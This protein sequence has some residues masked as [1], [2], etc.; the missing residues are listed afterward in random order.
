MDLFQFRTLCFYFI[1][2]LQTCIAI[3]QNIGQIYPG[4]NTSQMVYV[5]NNGLFR[6]SNN[7]V[8]AFGFKNSQDVTMFALVV[9]HINS[10][11]VVW[12]ANTGSMVTGSDNFV[13][14]NDGN[15]YLESTNGVIWS[16]NTIGERATAMELQDSGNLALLGDNGRILWQSFSHPTDTLL[17]N[18]EFFEGMQLKSSPNRNN[19]SQYLE[20]KSGNLV[21]YAG[22]KTPQIYWSIAND[23]RISSNNVSG[24]VYSAS[25][26]SNSWNFYDQRGTLLLQFTFSNHFELNAMWAA[27]LGSAGSISFYNLQMGNSVTPE[28]NRI[29]Q[30]SCSIPE[31]CNPYY[32]C[33]LSNQCQCPSVLSLQLN[34]KPQIISTCNSSK[35]SGDL[36]YVGEKL[37][38]FALGFV[39]PFLKSDI[40]ACKQACLQNCSCLVLFFEGSSGN[41]FLFDQIGSLQRASSAGYVSYVKVLSNGSNGDGGQSPAR[42]K[43]RKVSHILIIVIIVTATILVIVGLIFLAF[44]YDRKNKILLEPSQEDLEDD[45][46]LDSLSGMPVR[47]SYN[48]VYLSTYAF[49][50][51]EEEKL[52]EILDPKLETDESDERVITAI[53]VALWCIQE[54]MHLRPPMTKV[55]QMLEGHCSVPQPPTS[56]KLDSRSSF[57]KSKTPEPPPGRAVPH[58]SSSLI[59]RPPHRRHRTHTPSPKLTHHHTR[60][61]APSHQSSCII[62]NPHTIADPIHHPPH[63]SSKLDSVHPSSF[64]DLLILHLGLS[65]FAYG[66]TRSPW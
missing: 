21:L 17:L 56:S 11:K 23:S 39:T 53:K 9:I 52:K 4:F 51:R 38:Y 49:K 10:S 63:P 46:L 22:Y 3:T 55:V 26:M 13:F 12:T 60:A 15:V 42:G 28:A 36:L 37:D 45:T 54:D 32:V 14:G 20:I 6:L 47:F 59:H 7:S 2:L 35:G 29:P 57:A 34:C 27:V 30:S 58:P 40:N 16:T 44:Y 41:C 31:P 50:M 61:H 24:K 48:K 33:Y 64:V 65:V 8:F 43:S 19:L 25:L 62:A 1:L 18:Q 66:S 5:E